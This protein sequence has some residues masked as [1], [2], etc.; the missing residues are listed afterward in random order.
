MVGPTCWPRVGYDDEGYFL[1]L[2]FEIWQG[3]WLSVWVPSE[4]RNATHTEG[5]EQTNSSSYFSLG[6]HVEE[7]GGRKKPKPQIFNFLIKGVVMK[8]ILMHR[9]G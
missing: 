1:L 6:A 5:K 2:A 7:H 8:L 3:M 4:L 9:F